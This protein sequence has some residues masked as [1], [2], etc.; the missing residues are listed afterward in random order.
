MRIAVSNPDGIGDLILRQPLYAALSAAGHDLLLL[1]RPAV[2]PWVG[3][4]APLAQAADIE[5]EPYLPHPRFSGIEV[6]A[7]RPLVRRV[8]AFQPDILLV[9]PFQ[10][11]H[12]EEHLIA[13]FPGV[14]VVGMTGARYPATVDH[15]GAA[16]RMD[17]RI[18]VAANVPE[19]EKNRRL[20]EALLAPTPTFPPPALQAT[21]RQLELAAQFLAEHGL[22]ATKTW[23]AWVGDSARNAGRNWTPE[24][25]AAVLTH[26]VEQHGLRFLL[27]GSD[28]EA[29]SNRRIRRGLG[30]AARQIE[31]VEKTDARIDLLVG[32]VALTAGY[33]GRDSGPM[34]L[35]AA[36]GKPV[37][38]V[39]GGGTISRYIPRTSAGRIVTLAVPCRNCGGMCHL[40]VDHCVKDVPISAVTA[41]FDELLAGGGGVHLHQVPRPPALAEQMEREA[42]TTGRNNIWFIGRQQ[43]KLEEPMRR[44]AAFLARTALGLLRRPPAS[45][46]SPRIHIGHHFY[47]CGNLGDDLMLAGFLTA[48]REAEWT[49]KL[50]CATPFDPASQRRRFPEV[51]WLPYDRRHREEAIRRCDVWLGLGDTPF[52][53]EVGTW[54][55]DHLAEELELCRRHGKP[56][57]FLGVGC[58]DPAAVTHPTTRALL[59]YATHVWTRDRSSADALAECG[60]SAAVTAGADLAHIHLQRRRNFSVSRG[61]G[62]V[63]HFENPE[64]FSSTAFAE[65]VRRL[66]GQARDWLVQETRSLAGSES[67]LYRTLPADVAAQLHVHR[68]D[69]RTAATEELT[70]VWPTPEVLVGSR[71]H[72][73]VVGAWRGC[74]LVSVRR[75]DKLAGL[76][77]DLGLVSVPDFRNAETILQA[78]ADSR[79]VAPELLEERAELASNCCRQF[80]ATVDVATGRQPG[81]SRSPVVVAPIRTSERTAVVR[82]FRIWYRRLAR[83]LRR[84]VFSSR[85]PISR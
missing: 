79:P 40:P 75:N 7:L 55:L 34:H 71:Y 49:G 10:W 39:V 25:W 48:L 69:Y 6:A 9:A 23:A 80:L 17:V 41:A 24:R 74:R 13:A 22:A 62:F 65:V 81:Q 28:D 77:A 50:T 27:L 19:W 56:M 53:S 42:A 12:V 2:R 26:G 76:A 20:C 64:A 36:L 54:F 47:G 1:V 52:Q 83:L 21:P 16:P 5:V 14:R 30:A 15:G 43:Q 61:V 35:A 68:P 63:L 44:A 72:G 45:P 73:L 60:G 78:I 4:V 33:V 51:A 29:N 38:V 84:P 59:N 85:F 70:A 66:E 57:F 11:T 67:E 18:E 8:K 82:S 3:I 58:G 31:V 46:R 32:L 37:L